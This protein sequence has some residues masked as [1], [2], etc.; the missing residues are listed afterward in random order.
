MNAPESPLVHMENIGRTF[1]TII[2]LEGVNFDVG[3]Q[4]VVGLLGDNGAGKS[5]LI[6]VLTG[7]HPA[8][9]G[10]IYFE[11]QPVNVDSPQ[12]AR[13]LGFES[14]Y[15]DL[16]LVS[17]MSIDRNFYLGREPTR[18]IGPIEVLDQVTMR[19]RT[20]DALAHIGIQVRNAGEPV[21]T[22]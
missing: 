6:K 4:E 19:A 18:N 2:A 8:T 20:T 10:Q 15:Q 9:T 16:V 14:V 11:G 17:L 12:S 22:L 3:Y 1:G 13:G 7:I 5:T 21:G